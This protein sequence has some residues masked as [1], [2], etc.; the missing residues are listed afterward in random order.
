MP[1]TPES[2]TPEPDPTGDHPTE[3]FHTEPINPDAAHT[4]QYE[5]QPYGPSDDA[6]AGASA[7]KRASNPLQRHRTAVLTGVVA[8]VA[9]GLIGG[10]LGYAV[11]DTGSSSAGTSSTGTSTHAASGTE[12][13]KA[14]KGK[15]AKATAGTISAIN[16]STWTVTTRKNQQVTVNIGAGTTFGTTK[17]PE[18]Q[19]DFA[20]GDHI[21]VAGQRKGDTIDAKRVV[22]RT[23]P[24][25]NPSQAPAT[26]SSQ[27]S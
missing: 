6:P 12:H 22:K 18:Q 25:S 17:T 27:P 15:A 7:T 19:T 16:G 5:A 9:G 20:V 14:A 21:A 4:H 8:V 13:H 24:T 23:Q 11:A 10:G 2:T 26:P 1:N 3:Q